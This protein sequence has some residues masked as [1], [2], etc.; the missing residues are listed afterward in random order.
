MITMRR[1]HLL[2]LSCLLLAA[3][4]EENGTS[5]NAVLDEDD[6]SSAMLSIDPDWTAI[7]AWPNAAAE[8]PDASPDPGR[9][10][11][12][13]VLDDSSSMGPEIIPAK[14]AVIEALDAMETTDR[15]AVLALNN[16]LILPFMDV[17]EAKTALPAALEPIASNGSTPLTNT[18]RVARQLLSDEAAQA[19]AFGTYRLIVTTDGNANDGDRLNSE[20]EYIVRN[21]PIQI[22]TIGIGIDGD[23]VL[24]RPALTTFVAIGNASELGAALK[25]AVAESQQFQAITNFAKE[26]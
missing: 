13:I 21:T 3:C 12:A 15:V 10:I 7:T 9:E 14:Q 4:G 19:R 1:P 8:A 26:G 18:V 17:I 20:V 23:H 22:A 6:T 5:S 25:E 2:L 11:N 24:R 16:G